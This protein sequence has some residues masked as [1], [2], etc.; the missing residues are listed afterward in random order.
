MKVFSKLY[1]RQKVSK[2]SVKPKPATKHDQRTSLE[3]SYLDKM[4]NIEEDQPDT[5]PGFKMQSENFVLKF[6][7]GLQKGVCRCILQQS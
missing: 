4:D 1:Q 3:K 5:L 7:T 2:S 6:V